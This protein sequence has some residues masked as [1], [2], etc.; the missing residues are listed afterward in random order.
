MGAIEQTLQAVDERLG[1]SMQVV[2]ICGR[3]KA[4][5]QRLESR[6]A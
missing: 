4:L 6:C 5:I 2:A 1:G 3:N